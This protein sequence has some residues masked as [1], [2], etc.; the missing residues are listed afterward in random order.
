MEIAHA[1]IINTAPSCGRDYQS[2]SHYCD[3]LENIVRGEVWA[4]RVIQDRLT[5]SPNGQ[6]DY[7]TFY[8]KLGASLTSD[9]RLHP[10]FNSSSIAESATVLFGQQYAHRINRFRKPVPQFRVIV[11]NPSES[12]NVSHMLRGPNRIRKGMDRDSLAQKKSRTRCLRCNQV[13]HWRHE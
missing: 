7:N 6:M 13:R 10:E 4:E 9:E 2:D 5:P 3:F 8:S 12:L 1:Q 11:K